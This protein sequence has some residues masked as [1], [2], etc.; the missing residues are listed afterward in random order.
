LLSLAGA[1]NTYVKAVVSGTA[2]WWVNVSV[3]YKNDTKT[4][5]TYINITNENYTTYANWADASDFFSNP[6]IDIIDIEEAGSPYNV[7][8]YEIYVQSYGAYGW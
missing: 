8:S 2:P 1:S 5:T 3:T 7:T 4:Y 6:A